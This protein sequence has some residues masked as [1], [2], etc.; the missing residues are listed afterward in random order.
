MTPEELRIRAE[1]TAE[2][3]DPVDN[4]LAVPPD[5]PFA[6]HVNI[7]P[8]WAPERN[9]P[10]LIL[11]RRKSRARGTRCP[12][13]YLHIGEPKTGT[14][15]LQDAM[16]DNR[17]WLSSR[18]VLLP[19]YGHQDHSRASRDLREA[20]RAASDPADPWAGEWDVLTRQALRAR[21]SAVISDELL[22]VCTARQADRAVRSLFPAEV[23]VVL[24]VRDFASLLP[25]EWQEKVKCRGTARW[26][27]WLDRVIDTGSAEDR[28]RRAWF[29]NAHDTLAI[30]DAWSQHIPPDH[31]HVITMPRNGPANLLWMRFASVLGIDPGGA[32]L[33]RARANSSL[34]LLEAEFLRRMNAALPEELPDWFYTRNIK[35]ILAHDVLS[36]RPRQAR[37]GLPAGREPWARGQAE[38]LVSG[39]RDSKYQVVGDLGELLPR[40]VTG[41]HAAGEP[42][43]LQRWP[44]A[45]QHAAPTGLAAE[46]LLDTAVHAAAALAGRQFQQVHPAAVPR[47]RLGPPRQMA[48]RLRWKV[49]NGP[50]MRRLLRNASHRPAVRLLR[51]VIWCVLTRP[52]ATTPGPASGR[53]E[54]YRPARDAR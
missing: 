1:I 39:L 4:D 36:A 50:R 51:V 3:L 9:T 29:W 12:R 49:L 33:T 34:G 27:E 22:A 35:R 13:I 16:W 15:F 53:R 24:A 17:S 10:S 45:G 44:A 8:E 14:T 38:L 23:H 43:E 25:A 7:G 30:L 26:E 52:N 46:Q 54:T 31:V 40:P 11:A 28:R 18:G 32:D 41:R 37:L 42:V 48:R 5:S 21:Q 19:G 6:R 20:P 2:P 47:L